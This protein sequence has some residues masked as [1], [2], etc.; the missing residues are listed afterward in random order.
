MKYAVI[1]HCAETGWHLEFVPSED[2]H[3]V[4]A[5]LR[6]KFDS[7]KIIETKTIASWGPDDPGIAALPPKSEDL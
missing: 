3:L 7:V 4:A 2:T 1:Y 5:K 6:T